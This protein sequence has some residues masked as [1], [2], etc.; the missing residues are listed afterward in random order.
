MERTEYTQD[1]EILPPPPTIIVCPECRI[2]WSADYT[3]YS[4][5]RERDVLVCACGEILCEVSELRD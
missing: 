1:I 3:D 4:W 2:P 5:M